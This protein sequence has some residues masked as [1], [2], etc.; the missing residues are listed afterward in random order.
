MPRKKRPYVADLTEVRI[1]RQG[2]DAVIEYLDSTVA[3]T[4][5]GLGPEIAGLSDQEILDRF[6]ETIETRDRLMAS[7]HHVA[8]EIPPG[9]PQIEYFE[10]GDQWVPRGDVLRCVV[11]DGGPNAEATVE[12]DERE[13]SIAQFG[14]LLTTHAGWGMRICFV[15][16]NALED[17]PEIDVREPKG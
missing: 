10:A 7:Y 9:S 12:I 13:L 8:V 4:H 1:S 6:N 15:P 11:G 17:E 2:E 14:R 16:D 5:F 3:T